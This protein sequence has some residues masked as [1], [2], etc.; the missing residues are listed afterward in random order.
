MDPGCLQ[1]VRQQRREVAGA[2]PAAR[3]AARDRAAR[4]PR[5]R[6][7][8]LSRHAA[9]ACSSPA[10]CADAPS[11]HDHA[12][13]APWRPR[14]C[15]R[16]AHAPARAAATAAGG[17]AGPAAGGGGSG[18]GAP[19]AGGSS[20]STAGGAAAAAAAADA[21]RNYPVL[22]ALLL[23][24]SPPAAAPQLAAFL[25]SQPAATAVPFISWVADLEARASS[26][27]ERAALGAL[28]G[29]LVAARQAAEDE[30][31]DELY[32]ATLGALGGGDDDQAALVA[33]DPSLYALQLA[34]AVTGGP[35]VREGYGPAYDA[36]M[37]VA[38][39]AALTPAGVARAHKEAAELAE[40][41]RVRRRRSFASILGRVA[42][43]TPEAEAA[44]LAPP[45]PARILDLLLGLPS[46]AERE[47]LLPDCFAPPP[48]PPPGASEPGGGGG[49]GGE[50]G[51]EP[52][53][54][55]DETDLLWCTPV[56]LLNEVDAR[57]KALEGP[58]GG[59]GGAGAA[60]REL[61]GAQG[62]TGEAYVRA[63]RRL[64]GAVAARWV[65]GMPQGGGGSEGS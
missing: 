35:V 20:R 6:P 32:A 16:R 46:E 62:L 31:M 10:A 55:G 39:P 12:G 34:E 58:E 3:C 22:L 25:R 8:A 29:R 40:D 43:A 30:R 28:C 63:L 42:I 26:G 53:G 65:Q 27:G 48:P 11:I 14:P 37:R 45:P 44:L 19:V 47:A 24:L 64:R 57:L 2:A 17:G 1:S 52:G 50:P 41:M 21:E 18:S 5:V 9:Q 54:G 7:Q 38:P 33:A 59:G 49:G 23:K 15:A 4:R 36:L 51:G 61:G 13:P 60:R 56:Q